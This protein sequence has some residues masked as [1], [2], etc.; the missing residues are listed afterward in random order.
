LLSGCA[1]EMPPSSVEKK[2]PLIMFNMWHIINTFL[3]VNK[4][5]KELAITVDAQ[6]VSLLLLNKVKVS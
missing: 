5:F 2:E 6:S 3:K 4:L 1:P